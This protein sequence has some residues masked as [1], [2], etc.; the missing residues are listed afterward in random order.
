MITRRR[1]ML[2]DRSDLERLACWLDLKIEP[3]WSHGHLARLIYWR[4]TRPDPRELGSQ[5]RPAASAGW[6]QNALDAASV[7]T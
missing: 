4:V 6:W 3:C 1:L 5:L 7:A 2:S